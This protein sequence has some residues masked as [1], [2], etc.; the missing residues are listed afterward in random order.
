MS[1]ISTI[2]FFVLLSIAGGSMAYKIY[3][4]TAIKNPEKDRIG[5]FQTFAFSLN[6]ITCFLPMSVKYKDVAETKLRKKAN[7]ALALFY[8][9]FVCILLLSQIMK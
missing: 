1:T 5:L 8:I 9:T 3:L 7:K 2:I 6:T 4:Q